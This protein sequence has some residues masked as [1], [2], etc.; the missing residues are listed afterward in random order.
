MHTDAPNR[1]ILIV[2]DD[3]AIHAVVRAVL[4]PAP[5]A[6]DAC[7]NGTGSHDNTT[8]GPTAIDY[9]ID[10]TLDGED[11]C[12]LVAEACR[13]DR[14]YAMAF[15]D[16]R[17]PAGW[18]GIHTIRE[19]RRI[20][21]H[22]QIAIC[23]AYSNEAR[24]SIPTTL[25][26]SDWLLILQ[27]PFEAAEV[28]QLAC[29]LT[30]KWNQSR[31]AG[32]R[33]RELEHTVQQNATL[34]ADANNQLH[35]QVQSL[36]ATNAR[37][38]DEIAARKQAD[39][40]IRHVAYHDSLTELPNRMLLM[41]RIEGCIERSRT[42]SGYCFAVLYCDLDNFKIVNDSLGH[43][44]GD[45][46][47]IQVAR[48][49]THA[50]RTAKPQ[51]RDASDMVA[52]LSGDEFVILVDDVPD[53][54][55]IR[56]IADRVKESILQPMQVE[57]NKLVLG[58]SVGVAISYGDYHDPIDM[59]RDADT[60]LYHAKEC[61]KGLVSVF[62]QEMRAKVT[63]RMDLEYDLRRALEHNQF[64]VYYQPII[65]LVTGQIVCVEALVRWQHPSQGLLGPE[66]FIEVAEE[67]GVIDAIGQVVLRTATE[68][69]AEW[70]MVLPGMESLAVSVNLSPRQLANRR[71]VDCI[72]SCLHQFQL[73]PRALR[74]EIT[75][76]TT[77]RDLP[78]IGGM[79][80]GLVAR[81]V[82]IHLD[83]FGTGYS[84]LS[85][86][87]SLPFS[88]IKLDRSFV[89]TLCDS[90]E[91]SVTVKAVVM[92]AQSEGIQVVAEGIETR[93][94]LSLLR[95][96]HCDFG[97]GYYFSRP[98]P[99]DDMEKYLCN[100]APNV[101]PII[102]VEAQLLLDGTTSSTLP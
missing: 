72:D 62:D 73:N 58:I 47:L 28:Q 74:L 13:H 99:A 61:G 66:A 1:R 46:L 55:H 78:K 77:I 87:H 39:D 100:T 71:I 7:S 82:E 44:I 86:L 102:A 14:P 8:L 10:S 79:L 36:A 3:P 89:S 64:V 23:T 63:A 17:M 12:R 90:P 68:Q 97:Q 2:D 31:E 41:E 20:D 19:I 29:A 52:R 101:P 26:V 91:S 34:L 22:V 38:A 18:D 49:L 54:Q 88:T 5:E 98:V 16:L 95:D 9:E 33:A 30:S 53:E 25:G 96:L 94:Q 57:E 21:P 24:Q 56:H 59:L 40:R 93:E 60:A 50:L 65:S 15:V 92:L 4:K 83:D 85:I 76:S 42:R 70:R 27:K 80:A 45:Q 35:E 75:E 32:R 81:G 84:S 51:S 37:L 67:T 48:K 6:T 11:A 69:V 43:R